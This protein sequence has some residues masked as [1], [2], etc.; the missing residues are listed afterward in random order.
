MEGSDAYAQ[1]LLFSNGLAFA[2]D[3]LNQETMLPRT[4]ATPTA[5]T[6]SPT[7]PTTPILQEKSVLSR[8]HSG[9]FPRKFPQE[10]K[11]LR[12]PG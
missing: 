3:C 8:K 11:K 9:G 5:T 12:A 4:R 2:A 1:L 6:T 7:P 10:K